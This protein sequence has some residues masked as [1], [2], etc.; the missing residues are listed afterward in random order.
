MRWWVDN[1][2]HSA[3]LA[4]TISYP[5]SGSGIIVLLNFFKTLNVWLLQLNFSKV[6][7][8]HYKTTGY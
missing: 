1:E 8:E 5:T 3:E 2:T 4:I 6:Y 7:F